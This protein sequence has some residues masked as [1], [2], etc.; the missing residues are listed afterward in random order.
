MTHK[1]QSS[2]SIM[3]YYARAP[4]GAHVL[5]IVL[6]ATGSMPDENQIGFLLATTRRFRNEV[7]LQRQWNGVLRCFPAGRAL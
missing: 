3:V 6:I 4:F 2:F 1:S 5:G 7:P